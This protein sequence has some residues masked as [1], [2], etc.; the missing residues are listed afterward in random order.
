MRCEVA[1]IVRDRAT[2]DGIE[3]NEH[4]DLKILRRG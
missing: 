3:T 2:P 4:R 1:R